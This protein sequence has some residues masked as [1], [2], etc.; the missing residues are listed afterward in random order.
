[1]LKYQDIINMKL[2][3]DLKSYLYKEFNQF[4]LN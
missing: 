3:A 4:I 1:M 2:K